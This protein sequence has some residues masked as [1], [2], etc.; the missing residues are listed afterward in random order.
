MEKNAKLYQLIHNGILV[1]ESPEYKGLAL[2]VRGGKVVLTPPQEE[3]ALAWCRKI[4]TPYVSDSVFARNFMH[5]F[6][7]ELGIAPVLKP[8]EIDFSQVLETV[9]AERKAKAAM[10]KEEKKELAAER[11]TVREALKEKY[12]YA[13]A[14]GERIELA[15]YMTEPSGIFMGRGKHPLRGRWK[16]GATQSDVTLNLSPDAPPLPGEWKEIVWQSESLWVARWEDKLTGKLKYIWLHDT[17]PIKQA[18]EAQKFDKAIELAEKIER[19][20]EA[21]L[22]NL[23]DENTKRRRIATACYLIDALCLRVGDEKDPEEA[24]TVGATTLRPEHIRLHQDGT[25][26]F[27]FLGK[28]SVLWH[29][30]IELPEIV[31]ENLHELAAKARPSN[32]GKK[33]AAGNKPQLFYDISSRNVNAFL[34]Q[35]MPG[36]TAK[37]FRTHHATHVV[38][39]TLDNADVTQE[40]PDYR[41]WQ[42]A[43]QANTQAAILCNHTKKAPANW[44]ERKKRYR[45][46]EKKAAERIAKIQMELKKLKESLPQLKKEARDKI[47]AAKGKEKKQQVRERYDKRLLMLEERIA[48]AQIREEK[49]HLALGKIKTQAA[50]A[51]S[52]RSWNLGTS[53]KSYIDPRVYYNWGKRVDYDVLEKYYSKQLQ[54]KFMWV[55]EQDPE[56]QDKDKDA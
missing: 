21:I 37:V 51:M 20:R 6:S 10:S 17:A 4:G 40:D 48:A 3:M 11:K 26:E 56:Y 25:A 49:A 39:I 52:N 15:N 50:I 2:T 41:K 18:R 45:E 14:N 54:R 29:K 33:T 43:V 55:R 13:L 30:K 28:D 34:S 1:P 53:Q 22:E 46:R 12:G 5:D 27:R 38:K 42:A 7:R 16:A 36:L 35:L 8:D 44:A 19:V 31:L 23:S 24:D 32:N 9:V 47:R